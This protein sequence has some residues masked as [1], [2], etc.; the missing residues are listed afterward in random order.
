MGVIY[1]FLFSGVLW[2][3]GGVIALWFW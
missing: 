1:G 2:I 3:I